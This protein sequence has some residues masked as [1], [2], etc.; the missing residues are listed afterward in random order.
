MYEKVKNA[1]NFRRS[2]LKSQLLRLELGIIF[3]CRTADNVSMLQYFHHSTLRQLNMAYLSMN[4]TN[5]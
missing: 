3:F 2:V 5:K 1:M 4:T